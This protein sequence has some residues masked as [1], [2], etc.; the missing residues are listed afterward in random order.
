VVFGGV[1]SSET[2]K[3]TAENSDNQG[4]DERKDTVLRLVDTTVALGTPLDKS[5]GTRA[6][7][8]K[9]DDGNNDLTNVDVTGLIL[10]PVVW[11]SGDDVTISRANSDVSTKSQTVEAKSPEDIGETKKSEHLLEEMS[12]L[13]EKDVREKSCLPCR[14]RKHASCRAC[15]R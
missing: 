3:D 8:G 15:Q 14:H 4:D 13:M 5:V 7:E 9:S 10:L 6:E 2:V 11:R 12:V 1:L